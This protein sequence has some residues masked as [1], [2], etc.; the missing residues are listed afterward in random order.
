[1]RLNKRIVKVK[2]CQK[3]GQAIKPSKTEHL[4]T[5]QTSE[6]FLNG[7]ATRFDPPILFDKPHEIQGD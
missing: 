5:G 7:S 6:I 3:S 2:E 4:L 1:M